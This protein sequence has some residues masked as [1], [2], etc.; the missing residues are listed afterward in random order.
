MTRDWN[1]ARAIMDRYGIDYV[2]VGPLEASTYQP[3][4][5]TKFGLFLKKI[6][7]NGAVVIFARPEAP[8]P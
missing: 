7:D 6:Y 1:E 3:I 5:V 8:V 4:A 2:Y